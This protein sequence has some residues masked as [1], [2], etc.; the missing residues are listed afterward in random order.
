M[1]FF[2]PRQ[3]DLWQNHS[4]LQ[5][6]YDTLVLNIYE[7]ILFSFPFRQIFLAPILA[8]ACVRKVMTHTQIHT[9]IL[10]LKLFDKTIDTIYLLLPLKGA[11]T[12]RNG[13]LIP[14]MSSKGIPA[15]AE[16]SSRCPTISFIHLDLENC[17]P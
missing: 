13:A 5:D 4:P 2:S 10:T 11:L 16:R 14:R 17:S 15:N 6:I 12:A 8:K 7:Y 3:Y 1:S 9:S